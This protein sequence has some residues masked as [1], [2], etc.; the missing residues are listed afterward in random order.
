MYFLCIWQLSQVF[1]E[2]KKR[3][4][5]LNAGVTLIR[6]PEIQLQTNHHVAV[7]SR[8]ANKNINKLCELFCNINLKSV[9]WTLWAPPTSNQR[10]KIQVKESVVKQVKLWLK[11]F[12]FKFDLTAVTLKALIYICWICCRYVYCM[13]HAKFVST[14]EGKIKLKLLWLCLAVGLSVLTQYKHF[15]EEIQTR[16]Y[17]SLEVLLGSEYGPPADIWSVA[18]MVRKKKT[19][20]LH[21]FMVAVM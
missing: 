14:K 4:Y 7:T 21:G 6:W 17:R 1:V 16:Q 20:W 19:W 15:C 5:R 11:C 3:A 8:C 9:L 18:C 10:P 12:V 2:D 13:L